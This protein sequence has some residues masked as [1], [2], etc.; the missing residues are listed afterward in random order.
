MPVP[1]R[2]GPYGGLLLPGENKM[3]TVGLVF[4]METL[5]TTNPAGKYV[6]RN[7]APGVLQ[8]LLK[9]NIAFVVLYNGV[10]LSEKKMAHLLNKTLFLPNEPHIP[11]E[12]MV[13][14]SSPLRTSLP[15][16]IKD[17]GSQDTILVI[18]GDGEK[19]RKL[20]YRYGYPFVLTTADIARQ[21]D[22]FSRYRSSSNHTPKEK[23]GW[24]LTTR[25]K[26]LKVHGILVFS[27]PLDWELDANVLIH[28]CLNCSRLGYDCGPENAELKP[29]ELAEKIARHMPPIHICTVGIGESRSSPSGEASQSWLQFLHERWTERTNGVPWL[30]YESYGNPPDETLQRCIERTLVRAD[31]DLYIKL[32]GW[33]KDLE[34]EGRFADFPR[35]YSTYAIGVPLDGEYHSESGTTWKGI[36][37][38]GQDGVQSG[39]AESAFVAKDLKA[40]VMHALSDA[41]S[42]AAEEGLEPMWRAPGGGGQEGK[43]GKL[44]RLGNLFDR[45]K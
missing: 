41:Y 44:K 29:E 28:L 10:E 35:L 15:A 12:R 34:F 11:I 26:S 27:E 40:A 1:Q 30:V 32:K 13:A 23:H 24:R 8:Y 4:E 2:N 5:M 42:R 43:P 14:S 19:A 39:P 18:G 33:D 37:I 45:R 36:F 3:A 9:N 16:S 31:K 25:N 17:Y 38:E 6:Y 20:A 22:N 21:Y 7:G